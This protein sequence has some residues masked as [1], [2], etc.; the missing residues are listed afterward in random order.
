MG[1]LLTM[2]A[3]TSGCLLRVHLFNLFRSRYNYEFIGT[4][5][6]QLI[7]PLGPLFQVQQI[8]AGKTVCEPPY[9]FAHWGRNLR[10]HN[11]N[12]KIFPF[13]LKL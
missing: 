8:I 3:H 5:E 10:F 4:S 7:N 9:K 2:A 6:D 11:E 1:N 12:T 13:I